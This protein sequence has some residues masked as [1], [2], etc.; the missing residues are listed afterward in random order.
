M[1]PY[2]SQPPPEFLGFSTQMIF[3]RMSDTN[4]DTPNNDDLTFTLGKTPK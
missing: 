1:M 3:G 2:S 4:E